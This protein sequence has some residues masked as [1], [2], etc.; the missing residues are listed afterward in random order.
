MSVVTNATPLIYLTKIGKLLLLK[1][2]Y[3]KVIIPEE[4][5][6]EVVDRGK[7]KGEPDAYIIEQA[8]TDGWLVVEKAERK[9]LQVK[10]HPGEE[11]VLILAVEK[12]ISEV[13]IDEIPARTAA[14]ILGLIP[15]GTI[16]V[17]LKAVKNRE[18]NLEEFIE[19]LEKLLENGFRLKEEIYLEAI[20]QAKKMTE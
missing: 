1:K 19:L 14:R 12:K 17:L 8:I 2:L 18:I 3:G 20:Q 7:E 9:A 11:A 10:L 16:Y 6:K 5:K 15:R 13:I 4:V